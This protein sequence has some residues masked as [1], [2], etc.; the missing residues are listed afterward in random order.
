M[1][2]TAHPLA[3]NAALD[4]L[5]AG[6]SAVDAAIAAN[7]VLG[8]VEPTGC[9]I[10]GDLFAMV[11]DGDTGT[12]HGYNGSG[13]SPQ[14]LD[15]DTL[16]ARLD[17]LGRDTIPPRGV[18][19]LSVPG[20]VDGWFAL[21]ERWGKLP[22]AQVL[23]PAVA[24][25]QD[26]HPVAETIAYYWGRNAETLDEFERFRATFMPGG[27]APAKGEI[28]KNPDL[29]RT[30]ERIAEGG[31]AAFYEGPIAA[32][33]DATV[34]ELGGYLSAEDLAAHRGEW[35]EPVSTT[36][37]GHEVYELPLNGQHAALQ[38]LNILEAYDLAAMGFGSAEYLHVLIEA[39]PPR[40]PGALYAD[41]TMA[42]V[43]VDALVSK[44]YAAP[45]RAYRQARRESVDPG[46]LPSRRG[47]PP[48]SP[49]PT[50]TATWSASS[51]AT[52]AAWARAWSPRH[53]LRSARPGF[54]RH[55]PR[56]PQQRPGQA[57]FH[58]SSRLRPATAR[59]S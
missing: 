31:R 48:T 16:R 22:M 7:A 39:K 10:G 43:P 50:R 58:P 44:P 54:V 23:A 25:A 36:Y 21:H 34:R 27:R 15:A 37:R 2:A 53:G 6:G 57:P 28:F 24:I 45:R 33:I 14:S 18:L 56:P 51:R 4:I 30:Y 47:T 46:N 29:A 5:K 52:T 20:T 9:G 38:M 1:A 55:D 19:P 11:W 41:P 32:A 26:G 12:L 8:V 17:A 40:G 42:D 35:V 49:W 3:T 13:R 59:P